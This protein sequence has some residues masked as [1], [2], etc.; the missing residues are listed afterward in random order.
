MK[1]YLGIDYGGSKIGL[2]KA[3][4]E[5]KVA[6]PLSVIHNGLEGLK[7]VIK[8]EEIDELVVGYPLSLSGELSKQTQVVNAFI[9]SLE[10]L[11]KPIHKQDE[12]FSTKSAV[13]K[14]DDDASA[15]SLIL[16][17]FLEKSQV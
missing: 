17:T 7:R 11:G 12:R 14:K 16:Q 4:S 1:T 13:S 15:A 6:T 10:P 5:A 9:A 2:A 3:T 8:E